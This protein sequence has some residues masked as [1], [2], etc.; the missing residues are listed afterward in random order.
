MT[1]APIQR[2]LYGAAP[3]GSVGTFGASPSAASSGR[4]AATRRSEDRSMNAYQAAELAAYIQ[5]ERLEA[6][7][8]S[9]LAA[10]TDRH[11]VA[12]GS[13]VDRVRAALRP[14]PEPCPTT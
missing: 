4:L 10:L 1:T 12:I 7:S 3:D 6:A 5:H 9:R 11:P 2:S 14:T 13:I 8:R